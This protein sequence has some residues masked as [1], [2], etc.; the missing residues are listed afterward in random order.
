MGPPMAVIAA[1][2]AAGAAVA[3]YSALEA[4]KRR[5]AVEAEATQQAQQLAEIQK[6]AES[7]AEKARNAMPSPND[8]DVRKARRRSIASLA[9]R[10][11]RAS[12]VLTQDVGSGLG[13]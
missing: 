7:D 9:Q 10:R 5:K 11:G 12:T 1:S 13:G 3:G 4:R 6:K 2:T 8:S